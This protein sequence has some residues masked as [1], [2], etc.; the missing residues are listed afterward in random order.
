MNATA[1]T[2]NGKRDGMKSA[3]DWAI[4]SQAPVN[5]D[6]IMVKVQRL[7][8]EGVA[9]S[10]AKCEGQ[11]IKKRPI[12]DRFMEKVA[13]GESCHEWTGHVT[14]NGYGHI[15]KNGRATYAHRVA[16]EIHHGDIPDGML[17]LHK[18]DNRKCVN[19]DHLFLGTFN[20]NMADM[21]AKLRHAHGERNG[22]AKLKADQVREIRKSCR[23]DS[24][25]AKLHH[26]SRSLVSL[27][28]S[29][30]IWKFV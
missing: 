12:K 15:N 19:P 29:R 2:G 18:C 27:I 20:E 4:S 7:S 10:G 8:R 13:V 22:H 23:T 5:R 16:W 9:P 25:E 1:I 3:M 30:R 17:V 28:R 21:T 14:Y 6:T 24:E 26:V 11:M